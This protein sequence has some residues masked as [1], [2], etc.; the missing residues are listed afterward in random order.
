M[1]IIKLLKLISQIATVVGTASGFLLKPKLEA[2]KDEHMQ[3]LI[4]DAIA[5]AMKEKG[6]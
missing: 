2:A 3:K 1:D 6:L 5:N 4:E